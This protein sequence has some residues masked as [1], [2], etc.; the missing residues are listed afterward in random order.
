ML[1]TEE[2]KS[3]IASVREKFP[4][5]KDIADDTILQNLGRR[6]PQAYGAIVDK[7]FTPS[8]LSEEVAKQFGSIPSKISDALSGAADSEA[9]Q[10]I[11]KS[12]YE[13]QAGKT[14]GEEH[15]FDPLIY[16][17][18]AVAAGQNPTDMYKTET[19]QVAEKFTPESYAK[20][21]AE[22]Q[23]PTVGKS[24]ASA[25]RI[26]GIKDE[27]LISRISKNVGPIL[28][29][30]AVTLLTESPK[31]AAN[32]HFDIR[33]GLIQSG[34]DKKL[35][36]ELA[37]V[38]EAGLKKGAVEPVQPLAAGLT[39][40]PTPPSAV[41]SL[42]TPLP[43]GISEQALLDDAKNFLEQANAPGLHGVDLL[44]QDVAKRNFRV[45]IK[46]KD[47]SLEVGK[48]G[49]L[50][51]NLG[52]DKD[53]P[54]GAVLGFTDKQGKFYT[55]EQAL[56]KD[57][58]IIPKIEKAVEPIV[59]TP[60]ERLIKIKEAH[61]KMIQ[62]KFAPQTI[63]ST[64][65]EELSDELIKADD[66]IDKI[67]ARRVRPEIANLTETLRNIAIKK[68][69]NEFWDGIYKSN[70]EVI[71]NINDEVTSRVNPHLNEK[72]HAAFGAFDDAITNMQGDVEKA[73]F[74]FGKFAKSLGVPSMIGEKYPS[75]KP[76]YWAI[77]D[78]VDMSNE[79]FFH[80]SGILNPK[81]H[82]SLP[83]S[84]KDKLAMIARTSWELGKADG[85]MARLSTPELIEA[86][87]NPREIVAYNRFLD[88][89]QYVGKLE[90]ERRKLYFDFAG[91]T[92]EKQGEFTQALNN[93]VMRLGPGYFPTKRLRGDWIVFK[94]GAEDGTGYFFN[95][96]KSKA[97]ALKQANSIGV[98]PFLKTDFSIEAATKISPSD[99]ESLIDAAG[100][101][102]HSVEIAA[103]R[104]TIQ[105]RGFQ[106]NWIKRDFKEGFPFTWDNLTEGMLDYLEGGSISYGKTVGKD[107]A[108]KAFKAGVENMP[109]EIKAYS[110]NFINTYQ[111]GKESNALTQ[112]IAK[113]IYTWK[114]AL[115]ARNLV[116]NLTQPL[117]TTYPEI[118]RYYKGLE[119]ERVFA[120]TYKDAA[121]YVKQRMQGKAI[122]HLPKELIEHLDH[123]HQQ[124]ALGERINRQ[125]LG[126]KGLKGQQMD[127]FLGMFQSFGEA[128][129]RSQA[130]ISAYRI[131]KE[132]VLLTDK[133]IT[134]KFMKEFI[135]KTQFLYGRQNMPLA[136]E[137]AGT[138]RAP[139]K[140]AY[141]FRHYLNNYA[142][143]LANQTRS[144]NP[145]A[146]LRAWG[147]LAT[148]SGIA[149]LP[150]AAVGELAYKKVQGRT[151]EDDLRRNMQERGIPQP[152]QEAFL[153]GAPA[154]GGV[155][156]SASLGLGDAIPTYGSAA[157][158]VVGAPAGVIRDIT[159]AVNQAQR[160]DW[161][162]ATEDISPDVIK[163]VLRLQRVMKH[164][165]TTANGELLKEP[166]TSEAVMAFL[167]ISPL[168]VSKVYAKREAIS[169]IKSTKHDKTTLYNQ[170]AARALY[171]ERDLK[172][173]R[174]I[175]VQARKEG[176]KV[177]MDSL[178]NYRQKFLGRMQ[179]P[180][181]DIRRE[182]RKTEKAFGT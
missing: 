98:K 1:K 111:N 17:V 23:P 96:Y 108:E 25:M 43:L 64:P 60:Q 53:L 91:M 63:K 134:F 160:G 52:G 30:A 117:A 32:L 38:L 170:R 99:L 131:A 181:K 133:P 167:N 148:M 90:V 9:G 6:F 88:T 179:K 13:A 39:P 165:F 154:L 129:N 80:G 70:I 11:L 116:T 26:Y 103:L 12:T 76:I 145:G 37:E 105:A 16:G 77:Q 102:K 49:E 158:A 66:E 50:H 125:M 86:G 153:R 48:E 56:V 155:D 78:G 74:N 137:N 79:Q 42:P 173:Y 141:I 149:G 93:Q 5:Y 182:V 97:E 139:L 140:L 172:A 152:L 101:N 36:K 29:N 57:F 47:G 168:S 156:M 73:S 55:R 169:T 120:S 61:Q 126:L 159:K 31:I 150:L 109:S 82:Y 157:E 3:L 33:K 110:R 177:D 162:R 115:N 35:S 142:S 138:M 65:I 112:G 84:S 146:I 87:L 4:M 2:A 104:K 34:I 175:R 118:A 83:Q 68:S 71:D 92:P 58:S 107:A 144:G 121:E 51:Y 19:G 166:T 14:F 119:P 163:G 20:N 28:D 10:A 100:I 132:K 113:G 136:I 89:A 62:E 174:D 151:S 178:R 122:T 40:E 15:T 147:S 176:V 135:G 41:S 81:M 54:K 21:L 127:D 95:I 171:I 85:H 67:M 123:L 7:E 45:A 24:I 94:E 18:R 44:K 22:V 72:G 46:Y 124:N 180:S 114:L 143:F 8:T 161:T 75:F 164:G 106:S 69:D 27:K 130:A 59:L 128:I